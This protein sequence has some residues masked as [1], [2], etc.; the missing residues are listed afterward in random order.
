MEDTFPVS[1]IGG[2]VVGLAIANELLDKGY[3]DVVLLDKNRHYGREQSERN[4]GVIH[5]GL[6]YDPGSLM[7]KLCVEGVPLLYDFAKKHGVPAQNTGKLIVATNED[8]DRTLDEY[9]QRGIDNGVPG[10]KKISKED[11]QKKEPNVN[12]VSAIYC[13]TTGIISSADYVRTLERVIN[14]KHNEPQCLMKGS[15]VINIESKGG[16][17]TV[18]VRDPKGA[19]PDWTFNTE[20][21]INSAGLFAVDVAKMI[22]P[23][24]PYEKGYLRGEY[25]KF[26]KTRRPE[27]NMGANIYPAPKLITLPDGTK[28]PHWGIHLTPTFGLDAKGE[29]IPG[30]EVWVGPNFVD[31]KNPAD[32]SSGV[33][34]AKVF[35]DAVTTFFPGLRIDDLQVSDSGVLGILKTPWDFVIYKEKENP[36]C[37]QLLGMESPALTSSLAIARYV[38]ELL[39]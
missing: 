33:L 27:L 5:C 28:F 39:K 16:Y 8:E 1:I 9:V 25:Y 15:Q 2:G 38:A 18:Y 7:A 31:T 12:A 20:I 21:L 14:S 24:T 22:N 4:S 36:N 10:V 3:K 32:R 23:K 19:I 34:D 29:A 11:V 17:F 30:K 35:Y 13:P 37:I 6:Y 26:N